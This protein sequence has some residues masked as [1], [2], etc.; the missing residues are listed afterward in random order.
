MIRRTLERV[1]GV[2][3]AHSALVL[4]LGLVVSAGVV[5]GV[6]QFQMESQAASTDAG[7]DTT[8]AQK[9]AYIEQHYG[10]DSA[11][12][13]TAETRV[14]Y[15]RD[16]DGNVLSKDALLASLRFQQRVLEAD[17]VSEAAAD[18]RPVVGVANVVGARAAG[19]PDADL[20]DQVAALEDASPSEVESLVG[21]TLTEGSPAL[22]LLP[23]DYEPGSSEAT[24]R[25][26]LVRFDA[27]AG[28][29]GESVA[30]V[31]GEFTD[32]QRVLYEAADAQDGAAY[33]TLGEHALDDLNAQMQENFVT[34][35]VPVALAVILLVLA[36][37]YRDLVDI[38]VGFAG[39][40]L[41]VL[42]MF[43]ILGWLRVQAGNTMIIGVVLVVGLS[44]DYGLHVF[45][46]YREERGPD[47]GV[48]EPMTRSLSA[49]AVAL[50]LVTL[51]TGIG[52]LSNAANELPSI[53]N[54]A[55]AITLGVVSSFV[56][57]VTVVPA[58]K[59]TIDR[60]L[61][62]VGLDRRKQPLGKAGRLERVLA[63]GVTLAK[64][65]APVVIV[66]ALVAGA[67][68]G[69][70]WTQLDR[71]GFQQQTDEAAEWKQN[72]PGPLA[73]EVPEYSEQSAFV[74]DHY[75]S[76]SE[77]D[78]RRSQLLVEGEVTRDGAL[79]PLQ[80]AKR[81]LADDDAVFSRGG[82]AAFQ[83]PVT[84]MRAVAADDEAFAAV[85]EDADTDGDGVPERDLEAV[86]DALYAAAPEDASR[87]VERT[88]GEY[89]SLRVVVPVAQSAT[90]DAQ[91]DAMKAAAD[92]V[93][94]ADGLEATG[95][96]QGRLS[97]AELSRMA[98]GI[99][100]TLLLALAA[101]TVLLVAV[102]RYTQGS[103][104]LGALTALPVGLV[105]AFVVGGMYVLEIPLTLLTALLL[106]LV[107]GLGID[108]SIHV[109][110]RFV[111]ER[112]AGRE[113]TGALREAVT[114][115]G[116]ALLGSTLTSTGAFA[117]LLLLPHPQFQSFGALVV[118]ALSLSFV[119]S[120]FVLPS[121][122][123]AYSERVGLPLA[124]ESRRQSTAEPQD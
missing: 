98:D 41:S 68:G 116:G 94:A 12:D 62:Y 26:I 20:D 88:D 36:F 105:T 75:R 4:V 97:T 77:A 35:V 50:G 110:D 55:V 7:G 119:V 54:L 59:V 84:V 121:L 82:D 51:T 120:V 93:D 57:F 15:L 29:D 31:D 123:Y 5:A 30:G 48:R 6:S 113:T 107:V 61:E 76:P 83:S 103:A 69:A 67:A 124:G 10:N 38:L 106:S 56:I 108:Y 112:R 1:V 65:A 39:V 21:E 37:A 74:A 90:Y 95:V 73:W 72:L 114:G 49:V 115:T 118:L 16:D 91:N 9:Q 47:E 109:T 60:A 99:L 63:S 81:S 78:Q 22:E 100:E 64:R 58:L 2:V 32:A 13:A 46:R 27:P 52:F 85:L 66:L 111:H 80:D 17:A 43:G 89:R 42:W 53:R 44:V 104:T 8:V 24:T 96:G 122:L 45:T 34:L 79:D 25:R 19:D 70:A 102:F 117:T 33:F 23:R 101:V 87:V 3:T 28:D 18:D 11:R 14:V 92:S 71:Q 40:V 86:Y